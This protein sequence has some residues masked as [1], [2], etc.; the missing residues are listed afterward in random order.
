MQGRSGEDGR[1][2]V[3]VKADSARRLSGGGSPEQQAER[4]KARARAKAATSRAKAAQAKQ[5][6]L[7]KA[8]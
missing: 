7:D 5:R 2:V 3:K 1:K 4:A 8:K 6:M